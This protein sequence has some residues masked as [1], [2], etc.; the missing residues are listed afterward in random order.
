[1]ANYQ[2]IQ[3]GGCMGSFHQLKRDLLS[4]LE[5]EFIGSK[6]EVQTQRFKARPVVSSLV[7]MPLLGKCS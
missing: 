2:S 7:E 4:C 3:W 5:S 1:M 6:P